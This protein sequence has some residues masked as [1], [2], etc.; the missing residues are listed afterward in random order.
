MSFFSFA[1][2]QR[3][4]SQTVGGGEAITFKKN[5]KISR[6]EVLINLSPPME[7]KAKSHGLC[8]RAHLV[9][10]ESRADV[11]L[12]MSKVFNSTASEPRSSE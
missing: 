10:E 8:V 1:G 3:T 12:P 7:P 5:K 2:K 11:L 9:P 6:Q 4:V